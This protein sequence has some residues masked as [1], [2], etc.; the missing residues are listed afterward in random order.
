MVSLIVLT[1]LQ[2]RKTT[3]QLVNAKK[4]SKNYRSTKRQC[5]NHILWLTLLDYVAGNWIRFAEQQFSKLRFILDD[6]WHLLTDIILYWHKTRKADFVFSAA[7][8]NVPMPF[9]FS[10]PERRATTDDA[11]L[12]PIGSFDRVT[13]KERMMLN[14]SFPEVLGPVA[15]RKVKLDGVLV[16]TLHSTTCSNCHTSKSHKQ[17]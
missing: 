16:I 1:E 17:V 6:S 5:F 14:A 3:Q 7:S 15:R 2:Y 10:K 8:S 11:V 12:G 13:A 9:M 4:N